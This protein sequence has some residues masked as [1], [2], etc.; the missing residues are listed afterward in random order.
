MRLG[1]IT[2]IHEAVGHLGKALERLKEERVDQVFVLGDVCDIFHGHDRLEETCRLLSSA[3]AVGVW[4]NHDYRFCV[5]KDPLVRAEYPAVVIDYLD[6]LRPRLEIDGCLFS[7]R[8]RFEQKK[9]H[10][11]LLPRWPSPVR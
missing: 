11:T 9:Q 7:L 10:H 4:G 8:K 5:E 3:N 6:S 2:D 1:L